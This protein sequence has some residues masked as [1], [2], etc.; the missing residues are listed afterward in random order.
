ML[1]RGGP[2]ESSPVNLN[3]VIRAVER[4]VRGERLRHGVT[5]ELDLA[6]DLPPTTGDPIQ[7]Q[8]VIVNLMLNAFAAMDQPG[9][10]TRRLLVRTRAADGGR[11]EAEF[12][13][14]G[15]GIAAEVI[16]RLFEPF[17]TTKPDGLGMGLSI[18][19]TILDNHR[20]ALRAA[21]H[22]AGG[23]VFTLTLPAGGSPGRR[24]AATGKVS[25]IRTK[26]Q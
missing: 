19:R 17:V 22:P 3:D 12:Q 11:V 18:C 26:V 1:K 2:A 5:V 23:A 4:L 9:R 8:Q 15:A 10:V 24:S 14:S 25:P 7:L 16:D 13:D 20:G 6:P 21:N